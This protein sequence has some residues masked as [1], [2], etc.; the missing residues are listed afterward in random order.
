MWFVR[1]QPGHPCERSLTK[2]WNLTD[3]AAAVERAPSSRMSGLSPAN[4][5]TKSKPRSTSRGAGWRGETNLHSNL[6][7][8]TRSRA[9]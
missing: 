7:M 8:F 9:R 5:A 6:K 4:C 2:P 1:L 3:V